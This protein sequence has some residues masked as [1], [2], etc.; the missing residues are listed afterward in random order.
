MTQ[1]FEARIRSASGC[2][3]G[4]SCIPQ[5]GLTSVRLDLTCSGIESCTHVSHS[6][7]SSSFEQTSELDDEDVDPS[8]DE[9]V[10]VLQL[11]MQPARRLWDS[12]VV[13]PMGV[14]NWSDARNCEAALHFQCPCGRECLS[15]AGGV[16][17][18]Y[19]HRRKIRALAEKKEMGGLRDTVRRLL[20]AHYDSGLRRFTDTFVVGRCARACERAFA[21]GSGLSEVTFARARADVVN[22]RPWH[23]HRVQQQHRAECSARRELDGWVRLQRETMEGDKVSG[24]KW[25]TEKTTEKQLWNRYCASCDRAKQPTTG[26]ARLLYKIWREHTEIKTKPPTGHAICTRC[27]SF[28]SKRIE[29]QGTKGGAATRELIRELEE[30]V[31]AHAAFHVTERHYYDDAV[32]R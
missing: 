21:V 17:D 11:P 2:W 5:V 3:R 22:E 32:A 13:Y 30:K 12:M 25:Y 24:D 27:G 14:S 29:L 8:D 19:E 10:R 9:D 15:F 16:I 4:R 23:E 6:G 26:S 18:I 20:S 31:A 7:A 1:R 28:A